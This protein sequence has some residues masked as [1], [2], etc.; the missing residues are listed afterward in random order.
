VHRRVEPMLPRTAIALCSVVALVSV[1]CTFS[2]A[3][4][5]RPASFE[6]AECPP[7]IAV[8]TVGPISCGNVTVPED[9]GQPNGRTVRIFVFRIEPTRPPT[10]P[11]VLYVGGQIGSSFDYTNVNDVAQTL[12][13]HELIA[14]ELRGTGHSEP[15]L[16]CPEVDALSDRARAVPIDDVGMR[17]AF[18]AAVAS[19]RARLASEGVDPSTS[20]IPS[21]GADLLD[22]ASALSLA[23]WEV[24]SKGSTSRVV[25]EAMRSNPPGLRGVV[26]YNPEFPDTDPFVQAFDSTR[27]SLAHL[28]DMCDAD[29]RCGRRFPAVEADVQ[30]AIERLQASPVS[31]IAGGSTVL[32]DGAALLRSVRWRLTSTFADEPADLPATITA[33]A[34]GRTLV[35]TLTQLASHEQPSQ[36]YCGGYFPLCPADQSF[37]QGAYY[38]VL[39]RD[40]APFADVGALPR[41]AAG[42][43]SWSA[44]YVD[45]PYLDVCDAW[46]VPPGGPEVTEPVTS[47]VPVLIEE[48]MF[49]PFVGPSVIASGVAGLANASLAVSPTK[50]DGGYFDRAHC[51]DL[52]QSFLDD[53]QVPVDT[54]CY[55]NERLQFNRSPEGASS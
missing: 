7:E 15:D 11:P 2:S 47:G 10:G 40:E 44:D 22:V 17:A 20:D 34:H 31:V 53:P 8:A 36:T 14:V 54:S 38:S 28:A 5:R 24:L 45:G 48:G 16:S 39:C 3:D 37:S 13:G 4:T 51:P 6:A 49:S 30:R 12:S 1:D 35:H 23:D 25:L 19:C 55:A 41:L 26:L 42:D 50:G 21:L 46:D 52:R 43:P 9:R 33:I 32:M 29:P 18:M 27:A